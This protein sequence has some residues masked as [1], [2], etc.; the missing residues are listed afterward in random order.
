MIYTY[1]LIYLIK[2]IYDEIK[3]YLSEI[4]INKRLNYK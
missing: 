3:Y 2:L 4:K 1:I